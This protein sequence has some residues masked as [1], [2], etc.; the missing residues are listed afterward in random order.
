MKFLVKTTGNFQLVHGTQRIPSNRAAVISQAHFWTSRVSV[1]QVT[2]LAELVD[3]ATDQDWVDTLADSG[4]EKLAVAYF[5]DNFGVPLDV[6]DNEVVDEPIVK[7]A[8]ATERQHKIAEM[9]LLVDNLEASQ[10]DLANALGWHPGKSDIA[11][12]VKALEELATEPVEE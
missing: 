6:E 7:P 10:D 11:A 4:S 9:L 8:D 2:I 12:A 5:V 3:E 1:G